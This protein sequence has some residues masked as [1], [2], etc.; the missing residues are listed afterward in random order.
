MLLDKGSQRSYI[1]GKLRNE[2]N[3]P[4]LI[5]ERLFIKTFGKR[6]SKS[7]NVDIVAL[8]VITSN[9]TI[10][11]EAICTPDICHPLTNQSERAVSTNCNHVKNLKLADSKNTDTKNINILISLDYY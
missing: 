9:K 7:K 5:R 1:L 2:L 10:T 3:L 4:T 6:N 8:N 11:I